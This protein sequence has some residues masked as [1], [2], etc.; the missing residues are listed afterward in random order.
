[1]KGSNI[2]GLEVIRSKALNRKEGEVEKVVETKWIQGMAREI[3][4]I[5]CCMSW[6]VHVKCGVNYFVLFFL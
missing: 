3:V 6:C 4:L 2:V 5:I 1:M